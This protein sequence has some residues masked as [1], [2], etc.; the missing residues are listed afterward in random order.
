[1]GVGVGVGVDQLNPIEPSG[2]I[3]LARFQG[4]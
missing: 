1:V 4:L 3:G 2:R